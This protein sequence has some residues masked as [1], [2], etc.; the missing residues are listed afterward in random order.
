MPGGG[1]EGGMA[2]IVGDEVDRA[3]ARLPQCFDRDVRE[4][5][6]VGRER[7]GRTGIGLLAQACKAEWARRGRLGTAAGKM[8][9]VLAHVDAGRAVIGEGHARWQQASARVSKT[10][11]HAFAQT[12]AETVIAAV[13]ISDLQHGKTAVT[14]GE[15]AEERRQRSVGAKA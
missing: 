1:G 5:R 11:L 4:V 15:G 14:D 2:T 7:H 12:A 9:T 3:T 8:E 13:A 6:G 10:G